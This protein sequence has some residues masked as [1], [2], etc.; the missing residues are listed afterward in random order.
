MPFKDIYF[1]EYLPDRGG[2]PIRELDGYLTGAENVRPTIGGYAPVMIDSEVASATALLAQPDT[3]AGFSTVTAAMHFVGSST[4]LYQSND[5]GVVWNDVGRGGYG[6][7]VWDFDLFDDHIIATNGIDVP[8]F[9]LTSDSAATDFDDL[10]GN[11]PV[12]SV[13][14]RIREHV[15]L[16]ALSGDAYAFRFNSIGDPTSWP[17]PGTSTA[18]ATQAGRRELPHELGYIRDIVGGEKF[19]LVFQISGITRVTYTGGNTVWQV[20]TFERQIGTGHVASAIWVGKHCYFA[21]ATGFYRTDGYEVENLSKGRIEDAIVRS[22]ISSP[23]AGAYGYSVAYDSRT[24]TVMWAG[25]S[26]ILCYHV[27]FERFTLL[28]PVGNLRHTTLYSV[29]N[30]VSADI[31]KS[32]PHVLDSDTWKLREFTDSTA[33][34]IAVNTG[35]IELQPGWLTQVTGVESLDTDAGTVGVKSISNLSSTEV[36]ATGFTSAS[37]SVRSNL[38]R[39]RTTGRYHAFKLTDTVN[40]DAMIRGIRVYFEPVSQL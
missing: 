19:G 15:I 6:A 12:A 18:L 29:R 8:Q 25:G 9:K 24:N 20:D 10:S 38:Q 27:A 37:A 13:V 39:I 4:G 22:L 36:L 1:G 23:D 5:W 7:G 30:G 32:I 17:T 35:F 3:A 2:L 33:V 11:P 14:A 40:G 31:A 28:N 34:P 26:A 21:S 16:G